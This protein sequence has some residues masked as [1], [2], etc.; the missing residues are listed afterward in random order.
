[1]NEYERPE[2]AAYAEAAKRKELLVL[3]RHFIIE[4]PCD[5]ILLFAWHSSV[6]V[7]EISMNMSIEKL[8]RQ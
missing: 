4:I 7:S 6:C 2:Y 1:M 5:S 3:S 8:C